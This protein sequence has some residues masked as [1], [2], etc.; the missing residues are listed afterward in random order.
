VP[1]VTADSDAAQWLALARGHADHS[2]QMP[3]MPRDPEIRRLEPIW[4]TP[5]VTRRTA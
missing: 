2:Q 5:G 3:R 1:T 4:P